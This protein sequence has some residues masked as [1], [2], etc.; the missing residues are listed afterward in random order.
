MV[1]RYVPHTALVCAVILVG[2]VEHFRNFFL[3]FFS[4]LAN[5]AQSLIIVFLHNSSSSLL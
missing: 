2:R 4:V 1:A 3:R 5:V